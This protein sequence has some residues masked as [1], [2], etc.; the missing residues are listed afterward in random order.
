[1]SHDANVLIPIIFAAARHAVL[2]EVKLAA[3]QMNDCCESNGSAKGRV[4]R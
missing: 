4:I 3:P 1:M 2:T